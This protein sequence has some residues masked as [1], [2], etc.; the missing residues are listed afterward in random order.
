MRSKR[1]FIALLPIFAVC[2]SFV[3]VLESASAPLVR[4]NV[5]EEPF[6]TGQCTWACHNHGCDHEAV[7]PDWLTSDQ[8]LYGQTIRWLRRAG[9]HV[10][11]GNQGYAAANLILF[12]VVWPLLMYALYLALVWDWMFPSS[13]RRQEKA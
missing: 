7:L 5:P 3:A 11:G 10:G 6:L 4:R 8:G 12:C 2:L 1:W 13:T 9:R